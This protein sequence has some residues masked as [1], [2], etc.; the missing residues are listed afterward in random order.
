MKLQL[1][2]VALA[3]GSNLGDRA[4]MIKAAIEQLELHGFHVQK[5]S[6]NYSSTPV[7]CP[8]DSG[9]FLNGALI[10]K[11]KGTCRE[12][13]SVCQEI[14]QE[15][16]RLTIRE[17]NSPRPIDLDILLF[18]EEIYDEKDLVV[19]HQRMHLRDFVLEPLAEVASD[20]F[21]PTLK[22]SVENCLK[23]L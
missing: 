9:D 1:N 6:K 18:N 3:F 11:W 2:K 21:I 20:W 10:G 16:G 19:P 12:L 17:I 13:L 8:V 15:L 14:E 5:V 23:N 4:Q 7:D 22:T